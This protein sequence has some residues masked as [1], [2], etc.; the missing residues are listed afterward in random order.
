MSRSHSHFSK[1]LSLGFR[2]PWLSFSGLMLSVQKLQTLKLNTQVLQKIFLKNRK[3]FRLTPKIPQNSEH[4][5]ITMI[6]LKPSKTFL[7]LLD[8]NIHSGGTAS[9]IWPLPSSDFISHTRPFF[10]P[11]VLWISK[12]VLDFALGCSWPR[13]LHGWLLLIIKV[14]AQM[15]LLKCS[16]EW[17][18]YQR[19]LLPHCL[20]Q[21]SLS[22]YHFFFLQVI[23]RY[24]KLSCSFSVLLSLLCVFSRV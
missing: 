20:S 19:Q 14:S 15:S 4:K 9:K 5:F 12:M 18:L 11:P 6:C 13:S 1:I 2:S 7:L 10:W 21:S 16:H 3:M 23:H 17:P 8:K 22:L 24:L